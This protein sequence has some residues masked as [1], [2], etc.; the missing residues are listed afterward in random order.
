MKTIT[1]TLFT[2]ALLFGFLEVTHVRAQSAK[3]GKVSEA[4]L[5]MKSYEKDTS[6]TA[7][8]LSDYGSSY[9]TYSSGFQIVFERHTRIKILKKSGYDWANVSIPYF[10]RGTDR[11]KVNSIKGFT[12]NIEDGKIIKDKLESKVTFDEQMNENWSAKKFTM[13]NVKEGS[14]IE[15][16]YTILSDF[17]Y[18]LRDW[19]FQHTIPV[20]WSEYRVKIPEY[21]DYKF[22]QKGYVPFYD[23]KQEKTVGAPGSSTGAKLDNNAYVWMMKDVP[24]L[25]EEKYITTLSD[26]QAKIEFELQS[27]KFPGELQKTMTGN[28]EDVTNDLLKSDRFGTQLN[29]NGFFKDEIAAVVA[30]HTGAEEQ[31]Q[32]IYDLVKSNM[33][34][35][36]K[37]RVY[38]EAPIRKAYDNRTGSSAEI[39]LLLTAMLLEA[40]LDAAPVLVS[41]RDHGR[42]FEGYSPMLNKFNYVVSQVKVA[43]KEYLLDATEPLL[44]AG[45][46][47]VRCL[48]GVGRLIKKEDQRWVELKPVLPYVKLFSAELSIDGNGEI[49]GKATESIGGYEALYMR[50]N[51]LEE[52]ENKYAERIA[53]DFG[54]Y[55]ISKPEIKNLDMITQA[56]AINYDITANENGKANSV[57]YLNPMVGHGEKENPFKLNERTYPVDF[58]APIDET[59]I[60]KFVIPEGYEL[61]EVPKGLSVALPESGG[62]FI[63]IVQQ[64]GNILEVMS[65]I[66]ISKPM[67][68]AQ[69]Y[70]YLKEFYNQIIAKHAE[71]IVLKKSLAVE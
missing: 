48:N 53:K 57:I 62:K 6:A 45:M 49:K 12:Y 64:K 13:P 59:F 61:D 38:T 69:E 30:K 23:S 10:Q 39:N 36:G 66:S 63:Y 8:I 20:A 29:R 9:F 28:W 19:E 27:V 37:N 52:G 21:F 44:P 14:V 35:N 7:V 71:N 43:D 22:L 60:C 2:L 17:V 25:R 58:A 40:G 1:S 50:K 42:V 55:K 54:D 32:A 15:F 18:N 26:Y 11:E 33:K 51:I 4:E 70:P 67:F 5:T 47:P 31:M 65:K 16:S 24:A 34:W 41:T 46:L 3:F 56:L 68:Y